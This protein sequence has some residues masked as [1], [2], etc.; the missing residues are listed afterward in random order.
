MFKGCPRTTSWGE[1]VDYAAKAVDI[2]LT[3][4]S[5][6]IDRG[7]N[8]I[9]ELFAVTQKLMPQLEKNKVTALQT[10]NE[11]AS[12]NQKLEG[13]NGNIKWGSTKNY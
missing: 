6:M 12:T 4:S 13:V 11:I 7:G 9:S 3:E 5:E 2:K 8:A 10:K 1:G